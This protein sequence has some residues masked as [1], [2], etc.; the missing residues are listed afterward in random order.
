MKAVFDPVQ[1]KHN[2]AIFVSSGARQPSPEAQERADIL[3]SAIQDIGLTIIEP[4]DAGMEAIATVHSARYLTFL[5][6][7]YERWRRIPDASEEVVPNLHPVVRPGEAQA[8]YPASAVGQTGYHIMDCAA[9]IGADTWASAYASAQ[10]AV[11]AADLVAG[12]ERTAYALC[13]PPG[14]HASTDMAGGFCFLNNAAIAA[15]R[16]RQHHARVAVLD[17]DG[18]L[19]LPGYGSHLI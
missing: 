5:R 13:R 4:P 19:E 16:L 18:H 1:T 3:R 2:P 12:G 11:H 10:S 17:V 14:H 6:T 7:I 9:P 15:Q 8:G